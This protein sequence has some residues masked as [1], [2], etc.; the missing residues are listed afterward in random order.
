MKRA[1]V[2]A[3]LALLLPGAPPASAGKSDLWMQWRDLAVPAEDPALLLAPGE[4]QEVKFRGAKGLSIT[5]C[6]GVDCR[7]EGAVLTF[8]PEKSGNQELKVTLNRKTRNS[9][10]VITLHLLVGYPN[11]L[12]KNGVINGFLI[13][14]YPVNK[15]LPWSTQVPSFFYLLENNLL[16]RPLSKRLKLGDLGYDGR[17]P[18]PQYFTL[19]Y[20]LVKKLEVLADE[21]EA[22]DLPARYHF[23][24]GGFISPRSNAVRAS[25]NGAAAS[26]SRHM[27]GEAV[28]FIIDQSPRDERQDDM[29]KDGVI[30]VR[31]AFL[32]RDLVTQ[33]EEKKKVRPGGFGVYSPPRN[34]QLTMHVD[35]RGFAT[36]WGYKEYDP[37]VFAGVPPKKSLRPGGNR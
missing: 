15:N 37:K 20:A 26:Q 34:E 21:L 27:W 2:I 29:N 3:C 9:P 4:E 6:H 12:I 1:L 16:G 28:D 30:D 33:L 31:D 10:S 14:N 11:S 8:R 17:S 18:L 32:I 24:G 23:I 13:G 25:R 7:A 22:H 36:R 19:D 35:V 5:D